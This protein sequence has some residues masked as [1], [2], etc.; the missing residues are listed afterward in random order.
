MFYSSIL[1]LSLAFILS[2]LKVQCYPSFGH[3]KLETAQRKHIKLLP[4][5]EEHLFPHLSKRDNDFSRLNFED[6][7]Q[8][9]YGK[10][11]EHDDEKLHLGNM[12]IGRTSHPIILLEKFDSLTHDITCS[13]NKMSIKFTSKEAMEHAKST[14]GPVSKKNY[15]TLIT[16]H[17]HIGCGDAETRT[18]YKIITIEY[19]PADFTAVLT[20]KE[21]TWDETA[22]KFELR[23]GSIVHPALGVQRNLPRDLSSRIGAALIPGGGPPAAL[24]GYSLCNTDGSRHLGGFVDSACSPWRKEAVIADI[25]ESFGTEN[26]TLELT[27]GDPNKDE[28]LLG[29]K[30]ADTQIRCIGCYF[31]INA[32]YQAWASRAKLGETPE[33]GFHFQPNLDARFKLGV[34]V[35]V[36]AASK[37]FNLIERYMAAQIPAY[38]LQKF[39]KF[40]PEVLPGPG[41][42]LQGKIRVDLETGFTLKT[43][44][45]SISA[46]SRASESIKTDSLE[47]VKFEPMFHINHLSVVGEINPYLRLGIGFGFELFE[48]K[49][50]IGLFGGV[51]SYIRNSLSFCLDRPSD[52]KSKS[53]TLA[54]VASQFR[55]DGGAK[56]FFDVPGLGWFKE[57][58]ANAVGGIVLWRNIRAF[59]PFFTKGTCEG[60]VDV[61]TGYGPGSLVHSRTW[62]SEQLQRE[63][64]NTRARTVKVDEH[65][66]LRYSGTR[67]ITKDNAGTGKFAQLV[68]TKDM[69]NAMEI[70]TT[71]EN[72]DCSKDWSK[73]NLSKVFDEHP[74]L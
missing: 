45:A 72:T 24:L 51:Q 65:N 53:P 3:E 57:A 22:E 67:P 4:I 41:I 25:V 23:V 36:P 18:P 9:F 61:F 33:V 44:K 7:L 74:D 49:V 19:K 59:E 28:Y 6:S 43:G 14:W 52:K 39:G 2:A 71:G 1:F 46:S 21:A 29:E 42:E 54:A 11:D 73:E 8:F 10:V 60:S 12:T 58:M 35:L 27:L 15:F 31:K 40:L 38:D 13:G 34:K 32:V 16:H 50:K 26:K 5:R 69:E 66:C 56:V 63:F 62:T 30:G 37:D 64:E 68:L 20:R 17:E 70:V 48:G 47:D 55:M